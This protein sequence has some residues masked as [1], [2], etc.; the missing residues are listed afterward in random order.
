MQKQA[1]VANVPCLE[2]PHSTTRNDEHKRIVGKPSP[3]RDRENRIRVLSTASSERHESAAKPSRKTEK[4]GRKTEK[5]KSNSWGVQTVRL[6]NLMNP[7][8]SRKATDVTDG[9]TDTG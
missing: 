1:V 4:E 2:H 9:Q 8:D 5:W 6:Q 3:R 7:D